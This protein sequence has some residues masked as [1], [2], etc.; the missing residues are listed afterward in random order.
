MMLFSLTVCPPKKPTSYYCK[1]WS[2]SFGHIE[3]WSCKLVSFFPGM[4]LPVVQYS[5]RFVNRQHVQEQRGILPAQH[6]LPWSCLPP[7][8]SLQS[9][10]QR[11]VTISPRFR[12]R[13]AFG[14]RWSQLAQD[15]LRQFDRKEEERISGCQVKYEFGQHWMLGNLWVFGQLWMLGNL[16]VFW[17]AIDSLIG[18]RQEFFKS[19]G[20][21]HFLG[22]QGGRGIDP[23]IT[24]TSP[25]GSQN[26]EKAPKLTKFERKGEG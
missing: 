11:L 3:I 6:R 2:C 20:G 26:I 1:K 9:H 25:K 4:L 7:P 18:R 14:A 12:Q 13:K 17:A 23:K 15:S 5:L 19:A 21:K 8:P 10:G 24:K 22:F 16:W